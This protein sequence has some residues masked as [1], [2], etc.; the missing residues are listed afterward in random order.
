MQSTE[1]NGTKAKF[2][3]QVSVNRFP[4]KCGFPFRPEVDFQAERFKLLMIRSIPS[5]NARSIWGEVFQQ[6]PVRAEG[7]VDRCCLRSSSCGL[8]QMLNAP[9]GQKEEEYYQA[10]INGGELLRGELYG[11]ELPRVDAIAPLMINV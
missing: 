2:S 10:R 8:T 6:R 7:F 11:G 3:F 9:I 4:Q 1:R 5:E